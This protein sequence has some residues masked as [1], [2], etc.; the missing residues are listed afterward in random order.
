MNNFTD[1]ILCKNF[2]IHTKSNTFDSHYVKK[3]VNRYARILKDDKYHTIGIFGNHSIGAFISILA[4][5]KVG[6]PFFTLYEN[7]NHEVNEKKVDALDNVL[8]I[9][10]SEKYDEVYFTTAKNVINFDLRDDNTLFFESTYPSQPYDFIFFTSGSTGQPKGVLGQI[11]TVS[12]FLDNIS[13]TVPNLKD[14][15]SYPMVGFTFDAILRSYF[16]TIINK[17]NLFLGGLDDCI[18]SIKND[19]RI[20]SAYVNT[21]PLIFNKLLTSL[22][23]SEANVKTLGLL[24]GGECPSK[25]N[26]NLVNWK[27]ISS[28]HSIYGATEMTLGKSVREITYENTSQQGV[29]GKPLSDV[30]LY[31]DDNKEIVIESRYGSMGYLI[32]TQNSNKFSFLPNGYVRYRTGDIGK[33]E[34]GVISIVG[35][36]TSSFKYKGKMINIEYLEN[37]LSVEFGNNFMCYSDNGELLIIYE[38]FGLSIKIINDYLRKL[39]IPSTGRIYSIDKFRVTNTGKIDRQ[40]TINHVDRGTH[41]PVIDDHFLQPLLSELETIWNRK[42]SDSNL[43]PVDI[44]IDSLDLVMYSDFLNKHQITFDDSKLALTPIKEVL[45]GSI[46]HEL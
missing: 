43:K 27:Y 25:V 24:L 3:I 22:H 41:S 8:I 37:N 5:L 11:K 14:F 42:I 15:T 13:I 12:H 16:I 6:K 33:E 36:L 23:T 34:D 4:S 40:S 39:D 44:G 46:I 19:E 29:I 45:K 26:Y 38:G 18:Y 21:T 35:R 30:N 1:K 17:G 7:D 32:S 2:K 28:I 31:I 9:N 20:L 10:V